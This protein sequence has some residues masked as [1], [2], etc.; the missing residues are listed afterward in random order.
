MYMTTLA[1]IQKAE[2]DGTKPTFIINGLHGPTGVT[3]DFSSSRLYWVCF[4]SNEIWSAT[5]GGQDR[6]TVHILSGNPYGIVTY[7][8]NIYWGNYW[9]KSLQSS[10]KN[11]SRVR[12]LYVG[13]DSINHMTLVPSFQ[14]PITGRVNHCKSV[15]F[16][17]FCVLTS[18]DH[19]CLHQISYEE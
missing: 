14:Q 4:S 7:N 19:S 5:L 16:C 18:T 15:L 11:G 12:T 9:N 6:H 10:A 17:D 8:N 3:V 2:M 1:E 13:S